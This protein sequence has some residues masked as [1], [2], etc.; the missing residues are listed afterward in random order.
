MAQAGARP[1][2]VRRPGAQYIAP[3]MI[4]AT[5]SAAACGSAS[6]TPAR[7]A[8]VPHHRDPPRHRSQRDADR[9]HVR[10]RREDPADVQH[11]ADCQRRGGGHRAARQRAEA[12]APPAAERGARPAVTPSRQ[13]PEGPRGQ[14]KAQAGDN[15]R[16][17]DLPGGGS[18]VRALHHHDQVVHHPRRVGPLPGMRPRLRPPE[19][20]LHPL[21][22]GLELHQQLGSHARHTGEF[23]DVRKRAS[24]LPPIHDG[25]RERRGHAGDGAEVRDVGGVQVERERLWHRNVSVQPHAERH[26]RADDPERPPEIAAEASR[27][28][29]QSFAQA[30]EVPGGL[31][32]LGCAALDR[33]AACHLEEDVVDRRG[34][35]REAR[36]PRRDKRECRRIVPFESVV[37]DIEQLQVDVLSRADHKARREAVEVGCLVFVEEGPV[38]SRLTISV[39][40]A[41]V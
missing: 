4:E 8:G 23:A 38:E 26:A 16:P 25:R 35:F 21:D 30:R 6:V 31:L 24:T 32:R 34:V 27:A 9:R 29:H 33:H 12:A 37:Q 5:A 20:L 11:G 7:L 18:I 1:D 14:Q 10:R 3:M 19:P 13:P 36:G 22:P 15:E 40:E 28:G 41:V 2:P 17:D 39:P